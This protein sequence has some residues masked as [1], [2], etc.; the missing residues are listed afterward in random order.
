MLLRGMKKLNESLLRNTNNNSEFMRNVEKEICQIVDINC[1]QMMTDQ[2]IFRFNIN[3]INDGH[4]GDCGVSVSTMCISNVEIY[5]LY[6]DLLGWHFQWKYVQQK[7]EL[8]E[9]N[10]MSDALVKI[11]F[12]YFRKKK[13]LVRVD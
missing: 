2:Y 12:H 11:T 7:P 5:E 13:Q 1:T 9:C 10:F 6:K 8:I 4:K 3:L